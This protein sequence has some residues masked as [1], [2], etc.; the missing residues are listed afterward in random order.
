MR[1]RGIAFVNPCARP[2][3]FVGARTGIAADVQAG[4]VVDPVDQAVAKYW[5][6]PRDAVRQRDGVADFARRMR[7]GDVDDADA[8]AVPAV[9]NEV[10]E[11]SRIVVLLCDVASA[12]TARLGVGL[13]E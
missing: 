11:D 10:L 6:R 2:R 4:A 8:V 12:L 13:I 1:A 3:Q 9:E 7:V 5:V